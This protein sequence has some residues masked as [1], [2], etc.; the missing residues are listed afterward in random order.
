MKKKPLKSSKEKS[1]NTFFILFF[2]TKRLL[3]KLLMLLGIAAISYLVTPKKADAWTAE[4]FVRGQDAQDAIVHMIKPDQTDTVTATAATY[5]PRMKGYYWSRDAPAGWNVQTG[6]TLDFFVI[7]QSGGNKIQKI[8]KDVTGP[9][10]IV[11][12]LFLDDSLNY[13]IAVRTCNS[14]NDTLIEGRCQVK[15]NGNFSDELVDT[16][17]ISTSGHDLYFNLSRSDSVWNWTNGGDWDLILGDSAFITANAINV[18]GSG[19]TLGEI[20]REYID[21]DVLPDIAM[22]GVKEE[23]HTRTKGLEKKVW[24]TITNGKINLSGY[25]KAN[26]Y[27]AS[28]RKVGS[29][30]FSEPTVHGV[31]L[32]A[33]PGIYFIKD[34]EDG[35]TEKVIKTK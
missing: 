24:P 19:S 6:D 26:I 33:T 30:Q 18:P 28:G 10:D 14:I 1:L 20:Q 15:H 2:M 32:P 3:N 34:E 27:D 17:N 16:F 25:K 21:V 22:V 5:V 13:T 29:Y 12:P 9:S 11:K 35:E 8:W 23:N 4:G 31:G 7:P